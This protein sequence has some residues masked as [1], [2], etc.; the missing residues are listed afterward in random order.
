MCD[1]IEPCL[2]EYSREHDGVFVKFPRTIKKG[3]QSFII[4]WYTGYQET[5]NPLGMEV[6]LEKR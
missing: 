1:D 6:F 5:L 3:E 4:V 2:L